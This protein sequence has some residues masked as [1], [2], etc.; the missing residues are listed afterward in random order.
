MYQITLRE[1]L[2]E[3][4]SAVEAMNALATFFD[5]FKIDGEYYEATGP[6]SNFEAAYAQGWFES[7]IQDIVSEI[8]R[9]I[10]TVKCVRIVDENLHI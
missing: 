7:S 3:S 2:P 10:S 8:A 1:E 4:V 9:K 6:I 5:S